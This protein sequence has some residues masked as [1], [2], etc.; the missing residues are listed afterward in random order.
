MG[1]AAVKLAWS[2]IRKRKSATITLMALIVLAVML[3]Y[4]GLSVSL[5]LGSFQE[6][7]IE[8]LHAPDLVAYYKDSSNTQ[9]YRNLVKEYPDTDHWEDEDALLVPERKLEYGDSR[10]LAGLLILNAQ[11]PRS[12]SPLALAEQGDDLPSPAGN[13]VYLPYI[14]H[15]SGGYEVGDSF[16]FSDEKESLS[17]QIGGFFEEA[18]LGTFTG[19]A[20]KVFADDSAFSQLKRELGQDAAYRFLSVSLTDPVLSVNQLNQLL[21][22][23]LAAAGVSGSYVVMDAASAVEGNRFLIDMLAAILVVFSLLMVLIALIVIR[24]Q[25]LVQIEDYMVHIGV[26]KANGYT[27]RQIRGAISLQFFL[28]GFA[29]GLPG[30]AVS[31][32]VMPLAGN[33]ISSSL[34]LLW[35][36][37]FDPASALLSLASVV[38]LVLLVTMLSSRRIRAITPVHALQNGLQAH[39][40]KRNP[41]PLANSR[42][43][44]QLA[45][46]LKALCRQ[47][48]QN[49]MLAVI[50]AGLTFSSIFCVILNYNMSRDNREVI[51]LV[52]VER[53]SVR[54]TLKQGEIPAGRFAELEGMAGVQ[55]IS[56]LDDL[57]ATVSD[58]TVLLQVSEDFGKLETQTVY[59]GRH[60]QYDNEISLSGVV[61]KREG[62]SV[63]DEMPVTVNGVT[64]NYLITGLS[65]QIA[66]LGMVASMTEEGYHRLVPEY[67]LHSIN[68][69]LDDSMEPAVFTQQVEARYPGEWDILNVEEWLEGTLST[70]SGAVSSITWTITAVTMLVVSLILYLVIK[71]LILRRRREF[72]I[73]K[74]LGFTSRHLMT[75]VALSLLPVIVLGVAAGCVLG[76]FYSD[77]LFVLLLS[78][79][80]IYN[81]HFS[82]NPLQALLLCLTL[83]A[84]SYGVSMLVSRRIRKISVYS[85]ISD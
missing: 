18:L 33:L 31:Q 39:N 21:M 65:Q 72:G 85:L 71:T 20:L 52:G 17:F 26:L 63:G 80:G 62:K 15:L 59:R 61:A 84:M 82:F 49:V 76:Y 58:N 27:S 74:G 41:L 68:I 16:R 69:Y 14:F 40:F 30:L 6:E 12:L 45:M 60:P 83:V 9:A 42:L 13:R 78:S 24:F 79:L 73:L 25:I 67:S 1:Y 54:L 4:I 81:V 56:V 38:A 2:N 53:S 29:A 75:Q 57:S 34:G 19:G 48:K 64:L 51:N 66:Q 46:G 77:S 50:V 7:K 28:A 37:S 10:V 55:K 70:F 11:T 22:E 3:L 5:K 35:P 43:P 36:S 23:Q 32:A 8:E 44:L 47:T